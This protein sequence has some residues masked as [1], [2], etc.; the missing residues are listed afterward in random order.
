MLNNINNAIKQV[1]STQAVVA[2]LRGDINKSK[3]DLEIFKKLRSI[4]PSSSR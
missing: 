2:G 3:D 1:E 4:C